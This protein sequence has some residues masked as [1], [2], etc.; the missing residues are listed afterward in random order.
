MK[1]RRQRRGAAT[2]EFAF[3]LLE[4]LTREVE[5]LFVLPHRLL[6]LD[7]QGGK[8]AE[9]LLTVCWRAGRLEAR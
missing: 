4:T 8:G 9:E 7:V 6:H 2:V 3:A 1:S 5:R